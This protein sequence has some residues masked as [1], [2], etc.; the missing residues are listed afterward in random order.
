MLATK[1]GAGEGLVAAGKPTP[2]HPVPASPSRAPPRPGVGWGAARASAGA[3]TDVWILDKRAAFVQPS[4][5]AGTRF[6]PSA[7]CRETT[8]ATR[9]PN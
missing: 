5:T 9:F 3:G 6:R 7:C 1:E 8:K 2:S 4:A